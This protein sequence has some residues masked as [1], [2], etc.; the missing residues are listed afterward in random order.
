MAERAQAVGVTV[1]GISSLAFTSTGPY[2]VKDVVKVTVTTAENVTVT[3][4]PRVAMVIGEALKHAGYVSGT[5]TTALVFHYTVVAED[6]DPDGIEIPQNA[7]ENYN[8]STIKSHYQTALNLSHAGV[9]ADTNHTVDT[10]HPV[11]TS[12]AFASDA[13]TVYT[14]GSTVEVIVT[15]AETGVKVT[16]DESGALPSLSLLFGSNADPDSRKTAVEVSY[17]EARP[18]STKL[19]FSYTVTADTP[20]DTDGVQIK[21][22]SLRIPTGA[23]IEDTSGN[24]VAATPSEDGSSL[25]DIKPASRMSSR[26][27]LPSVTS[28]GIVFNEFLNAK[29]DKH[30][31]VELRNTTDSDVS[32]GGWKLSISVGNMTRTEV[33]EF[34]DMTVPGGGGAVASQHGAQGDAPGTFTGIHLSLLQDAGGSGSVARISR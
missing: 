24:A 17:K 8:G 31:W 26:P 23:S 19:V 2:K 12:V 30:D 15:F 9:A 10:A 11:I 27:I 7:L 20:I 21:E 32:L 3:G 25:V 4:I 16:S 14:A 6:S 28:A 34:P 13:P 1:S 33:V 18:G 22:R 29:T 5:G